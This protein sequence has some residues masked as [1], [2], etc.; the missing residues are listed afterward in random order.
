M[1][2]I[3]EVFL[4]ASHTLVGNLSKRTPVSE[5]CAPSFQHCSQTSTVIFEVFL[6]MYKRRELC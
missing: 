3:F 4:P 6:H 2:N 5:Y 1:Y